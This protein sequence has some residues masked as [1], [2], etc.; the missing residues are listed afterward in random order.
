MAKLIIPVKK[1]VVMNQHEIYI[2]LC[3]KNLI[4][5]EENIPAASATMKQHFHQFLKSMTNQFTNKLN[6]IAASV[7]IEQ[8][9][10]QP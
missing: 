3:M 4:M 5:T 2:L 6:I 8:H 7:I 10:H 1:I 9:H